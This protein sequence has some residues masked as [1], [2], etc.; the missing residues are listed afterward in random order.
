MDTKDMRN[1]LHTA[2]VGTYSGMDVP[3]TA[4][5]ERSVSLIAAGKMIAFR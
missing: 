1:I 5:A 4:G 3:S 2:K